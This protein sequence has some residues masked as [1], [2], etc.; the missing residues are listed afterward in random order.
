M[1]SL[2]L[3]QQQAS[4]VLEGLW[5]H[6]RWIRSSLN[7]GHYCSCLSHSFGSPAG[8]FRYQCSYPLLIYICISLKGAVRWQPVPRE[9]ACPLE[10]VRRH[11]SLPRVGRRC[12]RARVGVLRWLRTRPLETG[13]SC[14]A[15]SLVQGA[16][17]WP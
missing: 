7:C 6:I 14:L 4:Q 10:C 11:P 8:W 2:P 16:R 1:A 17:R 15:G 3:A 13:R 9:H 12:V 5:S